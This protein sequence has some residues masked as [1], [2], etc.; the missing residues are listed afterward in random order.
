VAFG[1]VPDWLSFV[2]NGAV[3]FAALLGLRR[4]RQDARRA[5]DRTAAAE[6]ELRNDRRRHELARRALLDY[7]RVHGILLV[8][9]SKTSDHVVHSPMEVGRVRAFLMALPPDCLPL[10]RQM[11]EEGRSDVGPSHESVSTELQGLVRELQEQ[12][13]AI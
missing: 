5:E 9:A 13:A 7:E 8:H 3:A 10:T 1:T 4:A 2:V 6:R 11:Y 12:S